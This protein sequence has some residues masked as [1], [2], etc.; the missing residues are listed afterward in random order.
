MNAMTIS[1]NALTALVILVLAWGGS[2][3]IAFAIVKTQHSNAGARI[4]TFA[5]CSLTAWERYKVAL[6][7]YRP[8]KTLES[9]A[10][11]DAAYDVYQ[12]D[13]RN[14]TEDLR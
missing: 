11:L 6:D 5:D 4:T 14:C 3:A 12:G 13:F 8:V 7:K 2:A 9:Q 1:R 10:Q